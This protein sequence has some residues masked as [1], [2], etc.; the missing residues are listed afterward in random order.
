MGPKPGRYVCLSVQDSGEGMDEETL[1][2]ATE[3]FFTT[4]GIGKGTGLGLSMVQGLAEQSGGWLAISSKP[5]V[6]TTIE[7]WLPLADAEPAEATEAEAPA[8]VGINGRKLRVLAVDDDVLVLM[9]TAAMLEDEGHTVIEAMSGAQALSVLRAGETV[10]LV[11]TDQAMPGMTGV[12]LAQTIKAEWPH[13]PIVMATGY[14]ELPAGARADLVRLSKPFTQAQ[15][16]E[17]VTEAMR[18]KSTLGK[19]A[20][21][22]RSG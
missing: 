9:N 6:G 16:G 21:F 19:I 7:I 2:R 20:S 5:G 12:E 8:P 10:D 3:P 4:K 14:A 17:M 11:I 1:R 13:L 15:L 18:P 22:F